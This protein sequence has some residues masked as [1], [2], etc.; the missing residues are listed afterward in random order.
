MSSGSNGSNG[1]DNTGGGGAARGETATGGNLVYN[2]PGRLSLAGSNTYTGT[3]T[4][5]SGTLAINANASAATNTVMVASGA[6]LASSGVIGGATT[7]QSGATHT[8]GNSP[9][10]QTFNSGLTYETGSS[11]VWELFD[12]TSQSDRR[13]G[14]YDAVNVS[15][16]TLSIGA[17]VASTLDFSGAQVRWSNAFWDTS[18]S[19]LVF[20]NASLPTL[21]DPGIFASINLTTD[22]FGNTLESV[23]TNASFA[24]KQ[25]G[26]DIYL[27]YAA[28]PEPSTYALLALA[29]AGIGAHVIRRRQR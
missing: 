4:V 22:A 18:Q 3:T 19:W 17:G 2:G 25:Q 8:P 20:Q 26:N 12:N 16:G 6:A 1:V 29:A 13:G 23:R 21:T 5:S 11:F 7:I 27:T 28:V 14:D 24:W 10:L 15:G 9:G